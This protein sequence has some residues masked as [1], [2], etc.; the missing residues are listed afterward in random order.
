MICCQ[1]VR[2]R[3]GR[4]GSSFIL[5]FSSVEWRLSNRVLSTPLTGSDQTSED[6]A[7]AEEWRRSEAV[8]IRTSWTWSTDPPATVSSLVTE[9]VPSP[10][11][12]RSRLMVFETRMKQQDSKQSLRRTWSGFDGHVYVLKFCRGWVGVSLGSPKRVNNTDNRK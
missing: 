5:P 3:S 11:T 2:S 12:F 9:K 6:G 8:N 7:R 4:Q 1:G 10:P